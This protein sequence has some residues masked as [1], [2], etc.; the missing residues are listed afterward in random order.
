MKYL[1]YILSLLIFCVIVTPSLAYSI[2]SEAG[3]YGWNSTDDQWKKILVETNG[4]LPVNLQDQTTDLVDLYLHKHTGESATISSNTA[5][6]DYVISVNAGY[7]TTAGELVC[8]KEGTNY[9]QGTVI[10]NTATTVTLDTPLDYAFTTAASFTF[11]DHDL[12]VAGS[13][14]TPLIFHIQPNAGVKWDIVRI[15]LYIE[16]DVAMDD[17]KFGG[18][19]ALTNGVVLRKK[20]GSYHNIFNVKTNGEFAQR[21]YDRDYVAKPP[22]GTGHSMIVR[23]TFGGQSK[24]GVVIRL[25]GDTPDELEVIIRDNLT[26]LSHFHVIAQGHV[27]T[28]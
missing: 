14:A 26:G 8:I 19:S 7:T 28:D 4:A 17:G 5:I 23:R 18:I 11:S 6:D 22:A 15:M 9:Y 27:V 1:K 10:S 24:N 13:A 3:I 21:A 25:D 16:D 12:S 20:D 2:Q